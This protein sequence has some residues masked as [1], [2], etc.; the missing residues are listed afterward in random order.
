MNAIQL[1]KLN[2]YLVQAQGYSGDYVEAPTVTLAIEYWKATGPQFDPT[3]V[4]RVSKGPVIR[5]PKTVVE[6]G[7]P[8][9][10]EES[11]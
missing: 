8:T 9:I 4:T 2:L 6:P 1:P 3:T 10:L 5:E 7:E 11:K